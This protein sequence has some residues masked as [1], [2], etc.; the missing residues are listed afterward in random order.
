MQNAAAQN[1]VST[2]KNGVNNTTTNGSKS[3][4]D[5]S[6]QRDVQAYYKAHKEHILHVFNKSSGTLVEWNFGDPTVAS[7]YDWWE[8]GL[9]GPLTV[10]TDT[11]FT[12]VLSASAS[13][14]QLVATGPNSIDSLIKFPYII[15][16][17]RGTNFGDTPF[18]M[19]EHPY[20]LWLSHAVKFGFSKS[21]ILTAFYPDVDGFQASFG[22]KPKDAPDFYAGSTGCPTMETSYDA[23]SHTFTIRF[24]KTTLSTQAKH[25]IESIENAFVKSGMVI[26][27]GPDTVIHLSLGQSTTHYSAKQYW[28]CGQNQMPYVSFEFAADVDNMYPAIEEQ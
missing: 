6:S 28:V 15:D 26:K 5:G 17:Y 25:S 24:F 10:P 1:S 4:A 27:S 16:D 13:D 22:P 11:D 23:K 3:T 20:F 2:N 14:I 7:R 19:T 9:S 12:E 8:K 18:Q 21:V